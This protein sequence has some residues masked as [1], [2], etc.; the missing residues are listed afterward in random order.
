MSQQAALL[1][2]REE[3]EAVADIFMRNGGRDGF[4]TETRSR[5]ASALQELALRDLRT[6]PGS[7]SVDRTSPCNYYIAADI[8]AHGSPQP[9]LLQIATAGQV[10]RLFR[11]PIKYSYS[12]ANEAGE[13]T[14]HVIPFAAT[15]HDNIRVFAEQVDTS[16]LP[17]PQ[18]QESAIAAGARHPEISIPAAFD[19]YRTLLKET[20]RNLASPVQMAATREMTT[21]AALAER[22][23]ENPLV[24]GHTR[25]SILH[26]Y[27]AGLWAAIRSGWRE[28]YT[29]EGDHFIV[30]GDNPEDIARSFDRVKEAI[31]QAAGY[32]KFTTDTSRLFELQADVRHAAAWGD[33]AVAERFTQ[34]LTPEEQ[35]W[36]AAE[37]SRPFSVG[38]REY[39]FSR[40]EIIR[41]AVKF[42]GSLKRNEELYDS[43]SSA[44]A[45]AA[46]ISN[47][48]STRP[49]P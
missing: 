14:V 16:F 32:T 19:A 9:V 25:V 7:L 20:G 36:V 3:A 34:I 37:F 33:S 26:L 31:R 30:S 49:R 1:F 43:S 38:G 40:Q 10:A 18:G 5:V 13:S 8:V 12:L 42:G 2:R 45:A 48:R 21:D 27:H 23:G 6:Y 28:G 39:S 17:R 35:S 29:A 44:S 46:S 24:P 22:D 11:G 4:T 47:R 41:L 15:D